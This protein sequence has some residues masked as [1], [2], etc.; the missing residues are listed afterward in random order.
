MELTVRD[1]NLI[2]SEIGQDT[3]FHLTKLAAIP[4]MHSKDDTPKFRGRTDGGT[5]ME[6]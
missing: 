2:T 5:R 6:G 4:F 1:L 3:F